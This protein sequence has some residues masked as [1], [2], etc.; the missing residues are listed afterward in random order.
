MSI[1]TIRSTKAFLK[2]LIITAGNEAGQLLRLRPG[3]IEAL[4][5]TLAYGAS[6]PYRS[7]YITTLNLIVGSAARLQLKPLELSFLIASLTGSCFVCSYSFDKEQLLFENLFYYY[8]K[9][10]TKITLKTNFI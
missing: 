10:V 8:V 7:I 9:S 2:G 5:L 3:A 6:L 1:N 4:N